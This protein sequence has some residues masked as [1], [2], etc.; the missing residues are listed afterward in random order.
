MI[1]SQTNNFQN[2]HNEVAQNFKGAAI[3][4]QNNFYSSIRVKPLQIKDTFQMSVYK[5]SI[6]KIEVA[7]LLFGALLLSL[8]YLFFILILDIEPFSSEPFKSVFFLFLIISGFFI[9]LSFCSRYFSEMQLTINKDGFKLKKGKEDIALKYSEIRSLLKMKDLVGYSINIYKDNDI[10]PI[11]SFNTECIH[12]A[13]AIEEL[14]L[15]HITS[16]SC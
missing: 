8:V 7:S 1:E 9:S 15:Y 10:K 5:N 4:Y 3:G 13:N 14:I 6:N 12:T 2:S 11:I 16:R